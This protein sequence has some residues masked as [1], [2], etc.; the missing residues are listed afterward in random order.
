MESVAYSV[1]TSALASFALAM[2]LVLTAGRHGRYTM[3]TPGAV[4]TFHLQPTPRVGGVGIY[5]AL[6]VAWMLVAHADTRRILGTILLAG[7]PCLLVGLL[8][9]VT[10]RVGIRTRLIATMASGA[11]ACV[12]SGVMLSRLDVPLLDAALAHAPAAL[13]LTAVAVGGVANSIN[14]IDGF[15]GL[16][17][18]T[19]VIALAAI[20]AIAAGCGD[21][22]L[23]ATAVILAAAV[24]GFW[25]VNFP[26]G[27][28]FLGDGGAYF[29]GFALAWLAVLLPM[30]NASVSP[31]ASLLVCAYPIIEVGYSVARRNRSHQP[32]AH[33]DRRHLHSLVA[34][35]IVQRRLPALHPTLQ[36]SAVSVVMWA[37]AAIPALFG[38]AFSGSTPVLV[39]CAAGCV[40]AYHLLYRRIARS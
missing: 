24:A 23:A 1:A 15:N 40:L 32:A 14:I 17:S 31:W 35:Q 2:V 39:A 19:T 28:L 29:A 37:C 22:P 26:W 20:A 25:L 12:L 30:R 8:E 27:K 11:L 6:L 18:G 13:L 34:T 38:I 9:D 5:L 7:V 10:K 3:D 36:N 16:A 33:P 4:Q 21:L